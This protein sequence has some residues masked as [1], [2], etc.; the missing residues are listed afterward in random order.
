MD[1]EDT[2]KLVPHSDLSPALAHECP[3]DTRRMAKKI[4]TEWFLKNT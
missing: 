4:K 2:S 3:R 1:V